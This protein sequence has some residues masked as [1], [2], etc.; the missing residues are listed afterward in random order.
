MTTETQTQK[1]N[2]TALYDHID[3]L[4][5]P[6]GLQ[7][8]SDI[9]ETPERFWVYGYIY[10]ESPET[11]QN[12]CFRPCGS[13][14]K[15]VVDYRNGFQVVFAICKSTGKFTVRLRPGFEYLVLPKY[16]ANKS[17]FESLA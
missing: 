11:F 14:K 2:S 9:Q 7:I 10:E 15:H 17:V 5:T 6:F 8:L 16:A 4:K 3:A 12:R 13:K 1:P